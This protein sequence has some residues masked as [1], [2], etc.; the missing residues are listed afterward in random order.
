MA[1]IVHFDI[2]ADNP[3]RAKKFYEELF[4]WKIGTIPGFPG[5]YEIETAD[6][7]GRQGVG[8]GLTKRENP[9]Q[10]GITNFIGVSSIDE[11]L[12]KLNQLGGKLIQSK[13]PIAGYGYIAVCTDTENNLF[14]LFQEAKEAK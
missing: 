14:G 5:Y 11:T 3:E 8:G 2:G 13:Q 4:G 1:T 10:T 7:N 12:A 9:Q 6:L